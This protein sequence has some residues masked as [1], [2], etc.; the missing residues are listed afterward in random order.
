VRA[1]LAGPAFLVAVALLLARPSES[2]TAEATWRLAFAG[3]IAG[4]RGLDVYVARVPGGEPVRLAGTTGRN[5]F[6]PV[7]SPN[8]RFIAF[9]ANPPRGHGS[10]I[11]VVPAGGGTPVNLTRSPGVA[12]WSPAWSPSGRQLAFFSTRAGG[13]D[14]W[15]MTPEGRVLRR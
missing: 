2:G 12:D 15:L 11:V 9:R 8:G 10:D 5:D 3:E 13:R 6:G 1:P 14:L 7:W 4:R